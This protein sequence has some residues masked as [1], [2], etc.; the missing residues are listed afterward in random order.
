MPSGAVSSVSNGDEVWFLHQARSANCRNKRSTK[1][2]PWMDLANHLAFV[3]LCYLLSVCLLFSLSFFLSL[4][5]FSL[6]IFLSA[7]ACACLSLSLWSSY[8]SPLCPF[9]PTTTA[10]LSLDGWMALAS[11]SLPVVPPCPSP[12]LSTDSPLLTQ[13]RHSR[14]VSIFFSSFPSSQFVSQG[15]H[16]SWG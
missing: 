16:S 10:M 1:Q 11:V 7:G 8:P 13:P 2:N 3:C 4:S 15:D 9:L 6:S 12:P 5:I 14:P